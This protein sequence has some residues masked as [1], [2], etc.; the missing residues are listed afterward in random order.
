MSLSVHEDVSDILVKEGPRIP[1]HQ[2]ALFVSYVHFLVGESNFC[3]LSYRNSRVHR[4][5]QSGF[6]GTVGFI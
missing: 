1:S 3:G 4:V 6:Y 2:V 5:F